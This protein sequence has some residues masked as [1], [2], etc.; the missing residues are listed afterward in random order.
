VPLAATVNVAFCPALTIVSAGGRWT[1]GAAKS[2]AAHHVSPSA[3]RPALH[4]N[5]LE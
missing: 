3:I 2:D 4:W 1:V 5:R